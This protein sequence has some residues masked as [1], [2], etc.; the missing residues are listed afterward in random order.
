MGPH[1]VK[2]AMRTI[3]RL[4]FCLCLILQMLPAANARF[5]SPDTMDP[6]LPGV[7]TNRYAYALNDPINKADPNGHNALTDAISNIVSAFGNAISS[8]VSALTGGGGNGNS[9][10]GSAS[11]VA[12]AAPPKAPSIPPAIVPKTPN[13]NL[14]DKKNQEKKPSLLSSFLGWITGSSPNE[15]KAQSLTQD[16]KMGPYIFG[17]PRTGAP[18]A[19]V[20]VDPGRFRYFDGAGNAWLDIEMRGD[21]GPGPAFHLWGSGKRGPEI[22]LVR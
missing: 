3:M 19:V 16:F 12:N 20:E 9:A 15:N 22:P 7:G 11:S 2:A 5:V 10:G 8:I 6:T 1:M 14:P 4:L 21:H 13:S 18:W 17:S